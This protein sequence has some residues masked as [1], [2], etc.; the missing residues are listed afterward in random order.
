MYCK[1]SKFPL[2]QEFQTGIKEYKSEY[3]NN[4]M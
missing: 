2:N 3:N 4:K 1:N